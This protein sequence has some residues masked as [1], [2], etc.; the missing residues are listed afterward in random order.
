MLEKQRNT[1]IKK[2]FETAKIIA[3]GTEL[4]ALEIDDAAY[5]LNCMLQG[6]SN[7]GFRLFNM[8]TGYMPLLPKKNEYKLSTEAYSAFGSAPLFRIENVGATSVKVSS[9]DN[10][11]VLQSVVFL[12][13]TFSARNTIKSINYNKDVNEIALESPVD[14]NLYSGDSVF[15][16]N[17][18]TGAT[19]VVNYE[20]NFSSIV[21]KDVTSLPS[22]GDYIYINHN[23]EWVKNT[24]VNIDS[25]TS[26]V[27][28]KDPMASGMISKTQVVFGP[29]VNHAYVQE[30][31]EIAPRKLNTGVF[32][33]DPVS[34][35]IITQ[36]AND[37][38]LPVEY[39][40]DGVIMLSKPVSSSLLS[41][42]GAVYLDGKASYKN[43]TLLKWS[44]IPQ[45]VLGIRIDWG[46]INDVPAAN[47]DDWGYVTDVVSGNQDFGTLTGSAKIL[48]YVKTE[49]ES[50]VSVSSN[51]EGYLIYRS[52]Q[53]DWFYIDEG[54]EAKLISY[55]GTPYAY[56]VDGGLFILR[57]G[58]MSNVFS[59]FFVEYIVKLSGRF[60]LV[61]SIQNDNRLV[62]STKDFLT[63][64]DAY[65]INENI[66]FTNATEFKG[67]LYIG[68]DKTL[69]TSDMKS[70]YDINIYSEN[71]G[72][73]GDVLQ[74]FNVD[75]MCSYSVD[76]VKFVPMPTT[77]A[78]VCASFNIHGCSFLAVYGKI[79]A[80]GVLGSQIFSVN[81]F[82]EN[83][84]PQTVVSGKVSSIYEDSGKL[85]VVSDTEVR[86]FDLLSQTKTENV[87]LYLFG[88]PIG[89]PQELMNV[90]K[91]GLKSEIQMSMEEMALKDYSQLPHVK[92]DG[93][94][95]TYCFFRD[96]KDGTM[97]IWGTPKKFG[98]YLKFTY[99]E[100]IALLDNARSV[101]D[102]PDE[103]V[104][105]VIDGLA[106]ELA[107]E[108]A[109][110]AD[111]VQILEAKAEA[112]KQ[113]ALLHD[114][115]TESYI[116]E[117]NR[118]GL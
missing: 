69:V 51:E 22:P 104:G 85:I 106:A 90:V 101:P 58:Q 62:V 35:S 53:G 71:R 23:N 33:F 67:K 117:P 52:S 108:Y 84:T 86:S 12:N 15:F 70:F 72:V 109:L 79:G 54:S 11:A 105:A 107:Y 91:Y 40:S 1:L 118:R 47:A 38:Y 6:W 14:I 28:L 45:D 113:M 98:E 59:E 65:A 89:R 39:S 110:P 30:T 56:N 55:S 111:K 31:I 87:D 61:S 19:E 27:N 4:T 13:N 34:V 94:P 63:F 17:F 77:T 37:S 36:D 42:L 114:N 25:S 20:S 82:N 88:M 48:D 75:A 32:D 8:K 57:N 93:D 95:V 16:G 74:N 64:T 46:S 102:I 115:E 44:N 49:K 81:S 43:N 21:L 83:W 112:S 10:A 50:Y 60:Y 80:D 68:K 26:T 76:G 66:D 100:P 29:M 103:Y 97:M 5:T 24:V 7:E 99:V 116:I 9:I 73:V 2:A 92:A 78:N 96:A 3:P 41:L 18:F